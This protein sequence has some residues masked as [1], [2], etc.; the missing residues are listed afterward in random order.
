MNAKRI[1]CLIDRLWIQRRNLRSYHWYGGISFLVIL[2]LSMTSCSH[3]HGDSTEIS[4]IEEVLVANL[5]SGTT[6]VVPV[7]PTPTFEYVNI[8]LPAHFRVAN[9]RGQNAVVNTD[10]TPRTNPLTND[11]ATLGRVLFYD[12]NLS[13]NRTIACASCHNQSQSFTD[14]NRL[15]KGFLGGLTR[16]HSMSLANA[17]YFQSGRFFWDE[18][19]ATLEAQVLMPFQDDTEM[20]MTLPLVV[21]RLREQTYYPALFQKAFGTTTITA[22][23]TA[24]ALAQFVRSMVSANSKYDIG[25]SRVGTVNTDFPNFTASENNGKRLFLSGRGNCSG[26]HATEAHIADNP[27]NNGVDAISTTDLGIFETTR[28]PQDLG[29]FKV[30]SLRDIAVTA[31]YMH[32]GRFSTLEQVV[33]HYNSGIRPHTNLDRRLR[34]NRGQPIRMN[35]SQQ[36]KQD[37]VAFLRTLTD[38]SFLNDVKF[39]NPFRV[40]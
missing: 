16:R 34:D 14:S 30:P 13:F 10:N 27:T 32:D 31:P 9:G 7:L 11:G 5:P 29:A 17:R 25:R 38:V 33:E 22:D 8:A 6:S 18:R 12:N 15:S 1:S 3:H 35:L 2:V 40:R 4:P 24:R 36:E 28:R 19:A 37:L 20:G 21:E 23:L 39:S 26:C